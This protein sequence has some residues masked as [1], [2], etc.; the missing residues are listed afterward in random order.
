MEKITDTNLQNIYTTLRKDNAYKSIKDNDLELLIYRIYNELAPK[1]GLD[2]IHK[3]KYIDEINSILEENRIEKIFHV[4]D[5]G[6]ISYHPKIFSVDH[7]AYEKFV[8]FQCAWML[9]TMPQRVKKTVTE[10][11]FKNKI[12][13]TEEEYNTIKMPIMTTHYIKK[14]IRKKFL[15][16]LELKMIKKLILQN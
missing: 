1:L 10:Y 6:T 11:C 4:S 5:D 9:E 8:A 2:E 14:Y 3:K 16:F 13:L 7:K 15:I 12:D